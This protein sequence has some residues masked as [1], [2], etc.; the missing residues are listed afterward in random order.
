MRQTNHEHDD[1]SPVISFRIEE[2]A[3]VLVVDDDEGMREMLS[4][5]LRE[6]GY[7]VHLASS[8]S[9][10]LE[11]VEDGT[12]KG[13]SFDL[14]ITDVRMPGMDG[15]TALDRLRA[16]GCAIPAIVMTA[17]PDAPTVARGRELGCVLL[18]KPFPLEHASRAALEVLL[19]RAS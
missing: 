10:L 4:D 11:V 19:R 12:D 2:G 6:E 15:F 7:E 14:I 16:R 17:F 5:T 13:S 9:A 18:E 3:R 8:G 1:D